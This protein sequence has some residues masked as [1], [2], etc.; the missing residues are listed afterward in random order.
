MLFTGDDTVEINPAYFYSSTN[1]LIHYMRLFRRM[2]EEGH[3]ELACDNHHA[4]YFSTFLRKISNNDADGVLG[5]ILDRDFF[6]GKEECG[7][8]LK[9]FD[10]YYTA[11]RDRIIETH[12]RVGTATVEAIYGELINVDDPYLRVKKAL[13]LPM[14]PSRLRQAVAQVL[15][16]Q[17]CEQ[18]RTEKEIAFRPVDEISDK[19]MREN[20]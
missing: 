12:R 5:P 2:C 4:N 16:E 20:P 19:P 15:V 6:R 18:V 3:I 1:A 10:D 7:G 11:M 17:G 14:I 8:F 9:F 13:H